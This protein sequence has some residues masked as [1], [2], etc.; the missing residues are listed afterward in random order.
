MQKARNVKEH[1]L[2]MPLDERIEFL[3]EING[4]MEKWIKNNIK[5]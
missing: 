3:E 4:G 2:Q 5:K 1:I